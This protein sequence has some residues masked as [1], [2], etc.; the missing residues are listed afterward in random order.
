M[1]REE[2]YDNLYLAHHGIKG[3]KWGIRRYQNSDGTLT[4]AGKKRYYDADGNL[5]FKGRIQ[6]NR[7]KSS[8]DNKKFDAV[9]LDT[10]IQNHP[11]TGKSSDKYFQKMITKRNKLFSE[12]DEEEIK[13][14]KSFAD[15]YMKEPATTWDWGYLF[16]IK[17]P[18]KNKVISERVRS[19]RATGKYDMEFL[20]KGLDLDSKT[21]NPL[22][23][24][25]LDSAYEKYLREREG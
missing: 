23:G 22:E 19:A 24:K 21:G 10:K 1:T 16:N 2:Y 9:M 15:K 5:T 3:Q 7:Q 17:Y 6:Y 20:E 4:E 18:S 11:D 14:G 8:I 25:A 12:I 13:I